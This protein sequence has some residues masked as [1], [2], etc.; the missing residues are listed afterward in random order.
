M[1]QDE[2]RRRG[3]RVMPLGSTSPTPPEPEKEPAAKPAPKKAAK[4]KAKPKRAREP[5]TMVAPEPDPIVDIP[6]EATAQGTALSPAN[7]LPSAKG[8]KWGALFLAALFSLISL[9]IGLWFTQL[10][11]ELFSRNTWLGW[12]ASGL[13]A[14]AG[15]ALLA[16]VVKEITALARLRRLGDL[17]Q[18]AEQ[19]LLGN[20]SAKA[21]VAELSAF[22]RNRKT[23]AWPLA[24]LREH[25]NEIIDDAD[26]LQ[27]AEKALMSPLDAEARA[28]IAGAAKRVSVVT[29]VNPAPAFDVLFTGYQVLAMLRQV[30]GLYGG[31]PGSLE[32]IKL[33]R[34]VISHLAVT[35]GLALSDTVLQSFLG[36]GL[37]GRL[38]AKLGEGT[39][40]GIMTARIGLAAMKLCRPLPFYRLDEPGLSDF[41]GEIAFGGRGETQSD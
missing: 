10:L 21:V 5:R 37:A 12:A 40:N 11:E 18:K 39:V 34:M 17:R 32:T 36:H 29:A 15:L 4:T 30:A 20:G 2:P 22:Y 27:L 28:L 6:F 38:S 9:G 16:L 25:Q 19:A 8:I 1:S 14:L 41:L 23:M 31:R 3:P 33:G 24:S 35:G 13:M 26:R 7:H